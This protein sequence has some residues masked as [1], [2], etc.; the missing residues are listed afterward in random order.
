MAHPFL[1]KVLKI[2]LLN[3]H[4]WISLESLAGQ[5]RHRLALQQLILLSQVMAIVLIQD[6]P[7]FLFFAFQCS[8]RKEKCCFG[9]TALA[10]SETRDSL[11]RSSIVFCVSRPCHNIA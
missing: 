8:C 3:W 5:L 9:A 11:G 4:A 7:F 6:N 2:L 1:T 10:V